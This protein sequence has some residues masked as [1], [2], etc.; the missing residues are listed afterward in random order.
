MKIALCFWGIA[1]STKHTINSI[2]TNIYNAL[3]NLNI[4]YTIFLH[5]YQIHSFYSNPRAKEFNCLL[6]NNDWKLIEPDYFFIENQN[7]VDKNLNLNIYKT[8]P[9]PWG[10]NYQTFNNHIRSLWSLKQVTQLWKKQHDI[11]PF[12]YIVYL[13]PDVLYITPLQSIFFNLNENEINLPY[14]H[15]YPVNDRFSISK[16]NVAFI[17]GSRFDSALEF[18]KYYQLHSERFLNHILQSNKII[19]KDIHFL[20]KRVRATGEIFDDK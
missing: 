9:D 4:E 12:D 13:R 19:P 5:S 16:P 1:R 7:E 17:Y 14:F 11:S 6:D 20:F 15:K 8:H 10:T 3:K 18:S 2:K